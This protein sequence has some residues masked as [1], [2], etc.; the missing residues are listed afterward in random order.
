MEVILATDAVVLSAVLLMAF[1]NP[2]A[3]FCARM[4]HALR[5]LLTAHPGHR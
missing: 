4:L 2:I 3:R 5:A 1:Q